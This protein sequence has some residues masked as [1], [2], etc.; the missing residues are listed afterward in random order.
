MPTTVAGPSGSVDSSK[1]ACCAPR[2]TRI[3]SGPVRMPRAGNRRRWIC[4]APVGG[5]EQGGV[6]LA[7][8]EGLGLL[9]PVAGLLDLALLRGPQLQA[10]GPAQAQVD[11][12][13]RHN[14]AMLHYQIIPVA[15]T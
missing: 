6:E 7:V 8:D 11:V 1:V 12:R 5:G 3:S 9:L 2:V 13:V 10:L 4:F 15:G 14:P